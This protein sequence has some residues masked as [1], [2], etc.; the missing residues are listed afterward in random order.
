VSLTAILGILDNWDTPATILLVV[1]VICIAILF[2]LLW[3]VVRDF[4]KRLKV[5]TAALLD[6]DADGVLK[7]I[8]L[9]EK[10]AEHKRDMNNLSVKVETLACDLEVV[11]DTFR[12]QSSEDHW[13]YCNVKRCPYV[14]GLSNQWDAVREDLREQTKLLQKDRE[15]LRGQWEKLLLF[16]SETKEDIRHI[17]ENTDRAAT[18][19]DSFVNDVGRELLNVLRNG[20]R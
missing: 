1:V 9:R 18:R 8:I 12:K 5:G 20:K 6:I 15:E 11:I 7:P 2:K 19:M 13:D 10:W 4:H 3:P 16:R 14:G 17:Y